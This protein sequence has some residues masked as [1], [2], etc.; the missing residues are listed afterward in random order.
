MNILYVVSTTRSPELP[1]VQ[2]LPGLTDKAD[3]SAILEIMATADTIG[4]AFNVAQM[5]RQTELV[6]LRSCRL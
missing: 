2:A 5:W 6:Q 3:D 4:R 1:Q